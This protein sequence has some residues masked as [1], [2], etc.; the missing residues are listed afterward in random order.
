V[1]FDEVTFGY[2]Q[3]S[4]VL[5]GLSLD[6]SAGTS[7]ALVGVNGCGKTTL[8]RLLL[9]THDVWGGQVRLDGVPVD[10]LD[11]SQLRRAI[12]LVFEDPITFS[13][14]VRDNIAMGCP[15]ASD[16]EIEAAGRAALIHDF[17]TK[18]P[19]GYDTLLGENGLLLS[20]GQRQRLSVARAI[21]RRPRVLVLDDATSALDPDSQHALGES[22]RAVMQGRTTL[23]ISH[24]LE[25]VL[26]AEQV[27][28]IG[29][30]TVVAHGPTDDLI[31]HP[32]V[33][34]ALRP[35]RQPARAAQS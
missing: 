20:G 28:V 19:E 13:G 7:L 26:L 22:L 31:D 33:Q 2:V 35:D 21:V 25:T 18:L 8:A 34:A 12:A 9:R 15:E 23:M 6:V 3:G 32:A 14:S 5:R 11:V 30:G 16:D 1:T 29:N 4:P 10:Q 24:R 17:V 27:A